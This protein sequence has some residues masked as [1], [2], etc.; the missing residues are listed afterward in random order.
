MEFFP[1]SKI[2]VALAWARLLLLSSVMVTFKQQ[3]FMMIPALFALLACLPQAAA[4]SLE[5]FLAN[6]IPG[7]SAQRAEDYIGLF[8]Q[9]QESCKDAPPLICIEEATRRVSEQFQVDSPELFYFRTLSDLQR[10]GHLKFKVVPDLNFLTIGFVGDSLVTGAM[11]DL[12]IEPTTL[13][14]IANAYGLLTKIQNTHPEN[15]D[16]SFAE[17]ETQLINS[18]LRI[19]DGEAT[20]TISL[21]EKLDHRAQGFID[22][23]ECSFATEIGR[24]LKIPISNIFIAA[25]NGR[26]VDQTFAQ[27]QKLTLPLGHLPE[28]VI[29]SWNANDLCPAHRDGISE[30]QIYKT[31]YETLLSQIQ[32][33]Q[34]ELPQ[35]PWGTRYVLMSSIDIMNVLLNEKILSKT[36]KMDW[37][38]FRLEPEQMT[39]RD[40]RNQN[41]GAASDVLNGIC[42]GVLGINISTETDRLEQLKKLHLRTIEA[43]RDVAKKL[44]IPFLEAHRKIDFL[45]EDISN[46]CFHPSTLGQ[47]KI[48]RVIAPLIRQ[49]LEEKFQK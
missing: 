12:K 20:H 15:R 17:E 37:F 46:D 34:L 1:A 5:S 42:T 31:I 43:Q 30:E 11:S 9:T 41:L 32:R 18:P 28:I 35:H 13:S 14:L 22:C 19:F 26:Q 8:L 49:A 16:S 23:E 3:L 45:A 21:H 48:G 36:I 33:A 2:L 6:S 24:Q 39:C 29:V 7:L 10:S 38:Q 40:L 27:I 44:N 25:E 4:D 47:K